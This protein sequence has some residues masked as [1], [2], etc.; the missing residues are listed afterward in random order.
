MK[1]LAVRLKSI[2]YGSISILLF[3]ALWQLAS[4]TNLI[5]N[6]VIPT[7]VRV[8]GAIWEMM[9]SGLLFAQTALSLTNIGV[10][11]ALAIVICIPLGLVAGTYYNKVDKV[12]LPFLRMCEKLNPF[13]LFPIFMILF[14]IGHLEKV[15]VVLWVSQWPLLFNTIDGVRNT[16]R[17]IVKSARSMGADSRTLFFKVIVPSTLPNI[18]TGIKLSAQ[19]AFF[20][21]IASEMVG[22]SA[23][24]GWQFLSA[25][26]AYNVPQMFG[27]VLY[28][29]VLAILINV[30][31]TKLEKHFSVWKQSVF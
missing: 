16:D 4:A 15:M 17:A 13:A 18:F 27:I 8:I 31:F 26:L 6:V 20:M 3:F 21:I 5:P 30:L 1:K 25:N 19:L 12:L 2:G 23:G 10:G 29:T 24:L 9:A 11:F 22:A 28:V 14:G 7:P